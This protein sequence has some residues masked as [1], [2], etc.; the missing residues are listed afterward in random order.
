MLMQARICI[1]TPGHLAS[2]PRVVKEADALHEAGYDVS[3]VAGDLTPFVRPLDEQ[4]IAGAPWRVIRVGRSGLLA[5]IAHRAARKAIQ[6]LPNARLP[7]WLATLAQ[8]EFSAALQAAASGIRAHLYI[9]HYVAGLAA[10]A[11]AARRNEGRL[12]YDAEDFHA[13]E[14]VEG[15]DAAASRAMVVAIERA[16][17]PRCVHMTAAS[18]LIAE[19]YETLYGMRATAILN[20]FPLD[21]KAMANSVAAR[22]PARQLRTYWFSQTVG[23][24]R[25]LQAFIIGM[26]RSRTAVTLDILGSDQWGHGSI[27]LDLARRLGLDG[28]VML[29]PLTSPQSMVA[30][31]AQYDVGLSLETNVSESRQRCLT[32]KIFV[33]LLAGI[34]VLMSDTPAQR[35]LAA[36][37]GSAAAVVSL[38]DPDAIAAQLDRWALSPDERRLASDEALQLGQVRYNWDREKTILLE[39]VASALGSRTW[40]NQ[41]RP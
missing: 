30:V 23:L 29:R 11:A 7:L 5:R 8:S 14:A 18:P 39:L 6:L 9:A 3:V 20:V 17:L 34:P 27:L 2:N 21:Q 10:A 25:G 31:A 12:S 16:L 22:S 32:N 19:A 36:D 37:L 13:G 41:C 38:A 24:D 40:S 35:L 26:A 33:Y 1:V 28:R 4:L 15:P